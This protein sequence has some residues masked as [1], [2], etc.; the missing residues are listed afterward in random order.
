M[1]DIINRGGGNL[2][3]EMYE[4]D[5]NDQLSDRSVQVQVDGITRTLAA[6]ESLVLEPGESIS[7]P[8][9]LYHRFFGE[10]GRGPVLTGEVS[11]VN[12]DSADNRFYEELG[13]FPEIEEDEP[14][15]HL[16]VSDY[17]AYL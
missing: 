13:R 1:E 8:P 15:L 12:D 5:E 9:R 14:P 7:L 6:G 2:V 17:E 11:K 4:A 16:L 3:L 10:K